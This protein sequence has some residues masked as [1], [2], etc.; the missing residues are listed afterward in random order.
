M[1]Q[2]RSA[3]LVF[4]V[5]LIF[6]LGVS[7]A[8]A[9][10]TEALPAADW[11]IAT[12]DDTREVGYNVSVAVD[13]VTGHTYISYYEGVDG[14]LWLA[15]TGAQVGN[16]GPGNTWECRVIDSDGIVGKY[17]SI[18]V[19]G[20][21]GVN[22]TVLYIAYHDV[23]TGSLKVVHGSVNRATG[24]LSITGDIIDLGE[25]AAG[26]V[27]GMQTAV[28]IGG[29]DTPHIA[30]QSE[31]TGVQVVKYATPVA[32]GT[33]NCG[34]GNTWECSEVQHATGDYTGV[35]DF[36]DI[37]LDN[38]GVPNIAFSTTGDTHDYPIV[39]H[40]VASGG[41]CNSG[42]LWECA[43]IRHDLDTDDT[44]EHLSLWISPGGV[45]HL[46][47]RNA[48]IHS[49]EWARDGI[50]D[51][52]CGS[53]WYWDCEWIDDIGPGASPSGIDIL[54]AGYHPIIVYQ[55]VEPTF[56]YHDLKVARPVEATSWGPLANCGPL[57]P[58]THFRTW[59]CED[60]DLGGLSH[61]EAEGGLSMA[62]FSNG[63]VVV[64]YREL[65]DPISGPDEGRL[66]VAIEFQGL[67]NDGFESGDTTR[68]SA[69]V[70]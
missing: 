36:L 1:C 30:Y 38:I 69:V 56:G 47:Y 31:D 19:G 32:P 12:V 40:L 29:L 9:S 3:S 5:A 62:Q 34:P 10:G 55:D 39:A 14:D 17:S 20:P 11:L 64:A 23:T 2:S 70:P 58:G 57:S 45:R 44:G 15:R 46:A 7:L 52:N 13:P 41:S 42:D 49:L 63:E 27:M 65:F 21:Y 18:A 6:T 33:G 28:T 35:G 61:A 43:R 68:W 53:G 4:C 37:Q 51:G 66:K 59:S 60:L 54:T 26:V 22:E 24:A 16:C 67:F 50:L 25:P 48:T 8:G